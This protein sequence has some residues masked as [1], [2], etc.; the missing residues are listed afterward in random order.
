VE[1]HWDVTPDLDIWQAFPVESA[2]LEADLEE[3]ADEWAVEELRKKATQRMTWLLRNS[4]LADDAGTSYRTAGSSRRGS[5]NVVAGSHAD[6][7]VV[8]RPPPTTGAR[9]LKWTWLST[10][11]EIPLR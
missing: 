5:W 11:L 3:V 10:T 7:H 8:F 6:G 4:D 9:R 1:I 2:E